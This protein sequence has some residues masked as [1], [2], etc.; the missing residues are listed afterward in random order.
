MLA[1]NLRVLVPVVE[2][3]LNEAVTP[4]G[5]PDAERFTLPENPFAPVTVMV[6]VAEPPWGTLA[7]EGDALRVKL[8]EAFTVSV[9]EA[10][11]AV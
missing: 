3:G 9:T 1:V 5:N 2:L 11:A 7:D 10:A 4:L 8:G 6:D